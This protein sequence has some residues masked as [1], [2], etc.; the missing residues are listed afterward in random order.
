[1]RI[2][3]AFLLAG[4]VL[5]VTAAAQTQP[6]PLAIAADKPYRH[7]PTSLVI[8]TTL[9]GLKRFDARAFAPD[10]L[11]EAFNF[12]TSNSS[13]D[14]TVFIFRNVTGSVPVW[15]DRTARVVAARA[16]YGGVTI[17]K[18]PVAFAPPGQSAA[19]GLI[20][21]Y[22][23]VKGP[24]RSTALAYLPLGPGWYVELR[25]SSTTI[26]AEEIDARLRGA[27]AALG[28]PRKITPQPAAV[29]IADCAT[30]LTF[31]G[32]ANAVKGDNALASSLFA[33]LF[34]ASR[35]VKPRK[36]AP[37]EPARAWCRDTGHYA[38]LEQHGVYRPVGSMDS[39]LIALNDAGRGIW[40]GPDSLAALL[41]SDKGANAATWAIA[42]DDVA[43]VTAYPARD[44]LPSPDQAFEIVRHEPYASKTGT[45]GKKRTVQV[46]SG[47]IK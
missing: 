27:I 34:G 3:L 13:E 7:E 35:D 47:S 23:P 37:V 5:P 21:S 25:Y 11:D 33:G 18:P 9:D 6:P 40:V 26:G 12:G 20:A 36:D 31:S 42:L 14:I 41:A 2:I 24:Y 43:T 32:K 39:Y 10:H 38:G 4:V 45:W 29:P 30:T 44:R 17:A 1:M 46:N 15:F 16:A 22:R 8:P 19:S 28:W